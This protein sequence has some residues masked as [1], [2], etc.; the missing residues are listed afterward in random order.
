ML[1]FVFNYSWV[2]FRMSTKLEAQFHA[3]LTL[4]ISW[5]DADQVLLVRVSSVGLDQVRNS[6][7]R[8]VVSDV[9]RGVACNF[10]IR[11]ILII[12]C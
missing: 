10:L 4:N 12:Y 3:K 6:V 11:Q 5:Y 8:S 1:Q 9:K 2:E 7:V